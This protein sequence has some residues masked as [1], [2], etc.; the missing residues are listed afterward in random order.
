MNDPKTRTSKKCNKCQQV[1][2]LS[3]FRNSKRSPDGKQYRCRSCQNKDKKTPKA[4][5]RHKKNLAAFY[6]R[7]PG[8]GLR[9]SQRRRGVKDVDTFDWDRYKEDKGNVCECCG[10]SDPDKLRRD[11]NHDT[12]LTRALLCDFCN[13]GAGFV[14]DDPARLRKLAD[15]MERDRVNGYDKYVI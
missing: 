13:R 4:K 3:D 14:A 12:G 7:N 6:A 5:A 9:R 15:I 11:H 1:K 8:Y 10:E 2:P